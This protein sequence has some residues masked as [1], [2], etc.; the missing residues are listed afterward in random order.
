MS[1][2]NNKAWRHKHPSKRSVQRKRYYKKSQN[3]FMK[4]ERWS[5]VD[6][7]FILTSEGPDSVMH[8]I[9]E[10]SVEAIQLKRCK[11]R[12]EGEENAK[13]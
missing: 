6:A 11:L 10:R 1:Y 12:K 9:L 3:A 7:N 4:G 2:E 5:D 8:T 13:R